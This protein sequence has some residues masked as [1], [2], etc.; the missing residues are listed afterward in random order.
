MM[1][2]A[3][4]NPRRMEFEFR[5]VPKDG[6]VRTIVT[7]CDAR[8]NPDGSHSVIGTDQDVTE[9]RAAELALR[10]AEERF[11][12]AFDHAPI[13]MALLD[14]EGSFTRVNDSLCALTGYRR[15]ELEGATLSGILHPEDA[16]G[17]VAVLTG[18][19]AE[20]A[21]NVY[22]SEQRLVHAESSPVWV[23]LQLTLI[24][25]REGLPLRFIAQV[26]D[27]TEQKRY[28]QRLQDLADQDALTGLLNR[29]SF[30]RELDLQ[31]ARVNRYG[32]EGALLM[33]DLDHFKY[34]N[35]TLGHHAGDAIIRSAASGFAERLRVSDV[36]ARLGGDE[37]AVL[38]PKADA[39]KAQ[40]VAAELQ[41]ALSEP[42]PGIAERRALTASVG[43][44]TFE[45]RL[46]G[47]EVLRR[48]DLAMY[49]AKEAGRNCAR[50]YDP[51]ERGEELMRARVSSVSQIRDAL[52]R[53]RFTMLAQPIIDYRTGLVA[54]HELLLRMLDGGDHPVPSTEFL[55]TA[56][57]LDM[58]TEIDAWVIRHA[59]ELLAREAL[60]VAGL[61][62][63]V[64][65][66]GRSLDT[67]LLELIESELER[68]PVAPAR[69]IFEVT[70]TAAVRHITQARRFG[71]R[72]AELGCGLALDDFGAGFGTFYY[73]KHLPFD[74]L[75]IDGE[76]VRNCCNDATDRTVIEAVVSIARGLGKAT[77]AEYVEGEDT[78]K[79]LM[80]LGVD[81]GQGYHHGHPGPIG[82]ERRE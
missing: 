18:A 82:P 20:G 49:E 71:H 15:A 27:V 56:E 36:L 62:V 4:A 77:I 8:R 48:A 81:Y 67:P 72:L 35:D 76:F 80:E 33:I 21:P 52:D 28:A 41:D 16:A 64:N 60:P 6:G 37:F 5:I 70:E 23:A 45:P 7:R 17:M 13:G 14:L 40:R 46:S 24:R 47:E 53:G 1:A 78:A 12:G 2:D 42:H 22:V 57:R 63:H 79:L 38:L 59:I 44:A 26:L 43:I 55:R 69:L 19:C 54:Q 61:P 29:R 74:Y 34:V 3:F 25:D 32:A 75:K 65:I 30:T 39:V 50:V 9:L 51:G 73:L 11:R 66:S 10:D 68:T 58:I 31:A